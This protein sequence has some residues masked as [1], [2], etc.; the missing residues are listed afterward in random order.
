MGISSKVVSPVT[1]KE[2]RIGDKKT[3]GQSYAAVFLCITYD[4]AYGPLV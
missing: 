3:T 1:R 4:A 2:I